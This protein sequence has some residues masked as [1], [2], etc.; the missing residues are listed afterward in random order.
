M[1]N[2]QFQ[3]FDL[4][5][6]NSPF[7]SAN[8]NQE[9]RSNTTDTSNLVADKG[10]ET[11]TAGSKHHFLSFSFYQQYFDVDTEQ[12][13]KRILHSVVP[14]KDG[15]FIREHVQ[16]VPDLYGPFWIAVTLVF[17]AAIS[18]NFAHYI[19]SLG[20][21]LYTN[22]FTLVTGISTLISVYVLGVPL[23]TLPPPVAPTSAH[24]ILV[25]GAPLSALWTVLHFS[26]LRWTF[27]IAAVV[28]SGFVVSQTVWEAI[29]SDS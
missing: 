3:S 11:E 2:L 15:N 22:D 28:F 18:A 14:K 29:R 25:S 1:S 10:A 9:F 17:A 27:L 21:D 20:E 5:D 12:V 6:S 13:Y 19:E 4:G 23:A 16:P 24:P 8:P 7:T 26:W